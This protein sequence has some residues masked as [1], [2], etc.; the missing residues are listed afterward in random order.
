MRTVVI[1]SDAKACF[2]AVTTK[3]SLLTGTRIFNWLCAYLRPFGRSAHQARGAVGPFLSGPSS[4]S[5]AMA[6][7]EATLIMGAHTV[8][9]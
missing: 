4:F 2:T 9:P 1:E 6:T 8:I 5:P 7:F 3:I